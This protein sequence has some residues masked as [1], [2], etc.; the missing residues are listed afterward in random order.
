MQYIVPY[1][2]EWQLVS[3]RGSLLEVTEGADVLKSDKAYKLVL[4]GISVSCL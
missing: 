2:V 1:S 4:N 3:G